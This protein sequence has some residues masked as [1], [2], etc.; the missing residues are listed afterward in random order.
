MSQL[1]NISQFY[2]K[3]KMEATVRYFFLLK[4][5]FFFSCTTDCGENCDFTMLGKGTL[6]ERP[7]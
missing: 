2:K 7:F 5:S 6:Q 3:H 4:A 1:T